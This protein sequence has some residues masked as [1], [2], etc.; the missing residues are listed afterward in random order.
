MPLP[1][2]QKK[3]SG[4]F[5]L[6]TSCLKTVEKFAKWVSRMGARFF[7]DSRHREGPSAD[8]DA[9]PMAHQSCLLQFDEGR[10]VTGAVSRGV[11]F[12]NLVG[13]ASAAPHG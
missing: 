3:L 1:F 9:L 4:S 12:I 7:N 8:G 13:S 10:G 5:I 11:R 6:D 2:R